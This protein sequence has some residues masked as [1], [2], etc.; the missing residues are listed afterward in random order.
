MTNKILRIS[1]FVLL[2]LSCF[3]ILEYIFK[4]NRDQYPWGTT[5]SKIKEFYNLDK[6]S[7]DVLFIGSSH[8]WC[9]F[10]PYLI[11]KESGIR[12]YVFSANEQPLWLSYYYI[13][14]SLKTQKPKVIVLETFYIFEKNKFKKESVNRINI[15]DINLSWNKYEMIK[16]SYKNSNL[17]NLSSVY[18]YH[19]RWKNLKKNDFIYSKDGN[20]K[21]FT[22]L[23]RKT[24][25]KITLYQTE[26]TPI[27][28]KNIK[29]LEK[30]IALTKENNI[31][32]VFTFVPFQCNKNEQ[33]QLKSLQ[34]IAENNGIPFIN[35]MKLLDS[36]KFNQKTDFDG[37]HINIYGANK[38]SKHLAKFLNSEYTFPK[39]VDSSYIRT[40]TLIASYDS[41]PKIRKF[42][43]YLNYLKDTDFYILMA[44]KDDCSNKLHNQLKILGSKVDWKNKKRWSYIGCFLPSK[45]IV[46]EYVSSEKLNKIIRLHFSQNFHLTIE[47]AG[48]QHGNT[49]KIEI[50]N[51]NILKKIDKRGLNIVV[52]DAYLKKV[53]DQA[54]FDTYFAENP[55]RNKFKN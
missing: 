32:L 21:G 23:F 11:Y 18:N 2:F 15:D 33:G 54:N 47:S 44:S 39:V 25:K 36:I 40:N 8:A 19:T 41:L 13:K 3:A 31:D 48:Y 9:S 53:I 22:P 51:N 52:Y 24:E 20:F 29:F 46:K 37:S 50:N 14:E 16:E 27:L 43:D 7:L 1:L 35:Y 49:A 4:P 42:N 10:N 6:N 30:I 5:T 26:E 12:S 17:F 55:T 28:K 38:V 45:K 34:K